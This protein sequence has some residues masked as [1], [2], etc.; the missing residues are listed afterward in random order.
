MAAP[1]LPRPE[2][3]GPGPPAAGAVPADPLESAARLGSGPP[4]RARQAAS[5]ILV[6]E[7]SG[8]LELLLVKRNPNARFMGGVWVFPGGAVDPADGEGDAA[9]RAAAVREL[10]EEAGIGEVD[11]AGL[12]KFSRW[13]TPVEL[14]VRFDTHFF[15]AALPD[16]QEPRVDGHECVADGWFTAQAALDAHADGSIL[17]VFPTIRQL[18]QL[19]GFT[20]IGALVDHARSRAVPTSRPRVALGGADGG[21]VVMPGE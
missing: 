3:G 20:R 21:R 1:E 19:R 14:A 6:R 11:P 13:I 2:D 17:L 18:E 15:I 10:A 5:V 4:A 12:V 16:G 8:L 7:R 9:H